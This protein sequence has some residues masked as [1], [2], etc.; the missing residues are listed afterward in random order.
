M[1]EAELDVRLPAFDDA[2]KALPSPGADVASDEIGGYKRLQPGDTVLYSDL[3][4]PMMRHAMEWLRERRGVLPVRL[5]IPEP[6]T[7]DS[8]LDTYAQMLQRH[9]R[10]RLVLLTHLSHCT[11]LVMPVRE[12]AALARDAGAEVIVDAAHSWGQIDFDAADLDAPCIAF[13]LH[14][15]IGAPLGCGCLY[16]RRGSVPHIGPWF[17]NLEFPADDIRSRIYTGSPNFAAWLTLPAALQLHERI[18]ARTKELRLRAL[19]D[20]WVREARMLPN[21]DVLTPDDATM[22][23]GITAFRLRGH[24]SAADNDAIVST[25]LKQH[26]V[27]T[28][29]RTGPAAGDC[30]RVTPAL[31]TTRADLERLLCGLRALTGDKSQYQRPFTHTHSLPDQFQ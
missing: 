4:Y 5:T 31:H 19:R 30:V 9:P 25:L 1:S 13:N 14:K 29:R 26:G 15:W 11:G 20:H 23:A 7:H 12:I 21:I 8:V 2:L 28:V 10:T 24:T 18:G 27:Y 6:A 22:V 3:D 16:I 17:G